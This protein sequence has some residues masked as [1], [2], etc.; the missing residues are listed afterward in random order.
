M[1]ILTPK[2]QEAA[3]QEERA[4]QLFEQM[5][6][7]YTYINT[8]KNKPA[9]V[10]AAIVGGKQ[11]VAV[12]ETKCRNVTMKQ[13]TDWERTWLVTFDKIVAARQYAVSTGVPLLGLLYLVPEDL[14]LVQRLFHPDGTPATEF[15]VSIT[16]TAK[17]VNWG[18][19]TRA[20]AFLKIG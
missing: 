7:G 13:F 2:G 3:R 9:V 4:A 19:A 8:P 5:F 20:N 17:T 15:H 14:L 12:A 11:V 1:D 6:P 16:S 10:D 18:S